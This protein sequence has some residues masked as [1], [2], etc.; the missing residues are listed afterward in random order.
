MTDQHQDTMQA[1]TYARYGG[2][3]VLEQTTQ[4]RPKVG[5]G[6]VLIQVRSAS[7]NPVDWKLMAGGLDAMMPVVFPVVAGWDVAGVVTQVG[8]DTPEFAVGEEVFAYARKDFVHGGTFAEYVTVPARSVARKPGSLDWHQAAGMPLAGLTAYRVLQQLQVRG[9]DTV[10]V[11]GAAGGVG[12][13]G[14]QIA[15]AL[16]AQ[17]VGTASNGNH[18]RLRALGAEPVEYGEGLTQR[19]QELAPQGFDAVAD[20]VGGVLD[21]TTTVLAPQGRHASI[22]DPEVL[23]AGGAWVWVR[24]D[25]AALSELAALVESQDFDLPVAQ[26]FPLAQVAQAF[27]LSQTGHVGGKIAIQVSTD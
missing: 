24:P 27:E 3:E 2:T 23:D 21:V 18:D 7:V 25:G 14:V 9:G 26:V 10:L 16:G 1:M 20:F 22:A 5:P 4:P 13:F 11:H 6:D 15:R 8:I 12:T 19:L 17:V